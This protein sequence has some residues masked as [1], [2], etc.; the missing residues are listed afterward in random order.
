[1]ARSG[2]PAPPRPGGGRGR[3][4][5][6]KKKAGATRPFVAIGISERRYCTRY[7]THE[8]PQAEHAVSLAWAISDGSQTRSS[9]RKSVLLPVQLAEG[10]LNALRREPARLPVGLPPAFEATR[11]KKAGNGHQAS[12]WFYQYICRNVERPHDE[13]VSEEAKGLPQDVKYFS[14]WVLVHSPN[15]Q[16]YSAVLARMAHEYWATGGVVGVLEIQRAFFRGEELPAAA[17]DWVGQVNPSLF[18]SGWPEVSPTTRANSAEHLL[19]ESGQPSRLELKFSRRVTSRSTASRSAATRNAAAAAAAGGGPAAASEAGGGGSAA[20]SLQAPAQ[21]QAPPLLQLSP[22]PLQRQHSEPVPPCPSKIEQPSARAAHKE[23]DRWLPRADGSVRLIQWY[24]RK[25]IEKRKRALARV[26]ALHALHQGGQHQASLGAV[27]ELR[28]ARY[29][30]VTHPGQLLRLA[31]IAS[32]EPETYGQHQSW[33]GLRKEVVNSAGAD[34]LTALHYAAINGRKKFASRLCKHGADPRIVCKA[35]GRRAEDYAAQNGHHKIREQCRTLGEF[36]EK[37]EVAAA[38]AKQQ[39]KKLPNE[40]GGRD[41]RLGLAEDEDEED[42]YG[43]GGGWLGLGGMA[44]KRE[45][46]RNRREAQ[47]LQTGF[48]LV[49]RDWVSR[50]ERRVYAGRGASV[51]PGRPW[52]VGRPQAPTLVSSSP[53]GRPASTG[54]VVPPLQPT[55]AGAESIVGSEEHSE[56]GVGS[57]RPP[58][59]RR[60]IL[61]SERSQAASQ[62]RYGHSNSAAML[63]LLAPLI[64]LACGGMCPE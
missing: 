32:D 52:R 16:M 59:T 31:V 40:T 49:D 30:A 64:P 28:T 22:A 35:S 8:T 27:T 18:G 12:T 57:P 36:L 14:C 34:G 43:D 6:G 60:R 39:G 9:Q 29:M 10:C 63:A 7:F 24:Y 38:V 23:I 15:H 13:E 1:M 33:A 50:T 26:A 62:V 44:A 3:L 25:H 45:Q 11:V 41:R 53:R 20:E 5:T 47:R 48:G 2:P 42:G 37:A 56:D 55:V 21:L 51:D 58:G 46:D 4:Q 61:L 19:A 17:R 54:P